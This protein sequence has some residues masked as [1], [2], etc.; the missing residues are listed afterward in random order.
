MG[1]FTVCCWCWCCCL[2]QSIVARIYILA[3]SKRIVWIGKQ[4]K[5]KRNKTQHS[6][7]NKNGNRRL[8]RQKKSSMFIDIHKKCSVWGTQNSVSREWIERQRTMS[9]ILFHRFS[10]SPQLNSM[11]NKV[12]RFSSFYV[13]TLR[14][15]SFLS[16]IPFFSLMFYFALHLCSFFSVLL[17]LLLLRF[18]SFLYLFYLPFFFFVL[19]IP[20]GHLIFLE[21]VGSIAIFMFWLVPR[22]SLENLIVF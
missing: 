15:L 5:M 9:T 22:F 18:Y 8:K 14:L 2:T 10:L 21:F 11:L 19:R 4:M 7:N 17:L 20:V 3:K 13:I 1:K 16:I 12:E 6:S